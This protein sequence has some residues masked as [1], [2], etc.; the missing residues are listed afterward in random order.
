MNLT[1]N[2]RLDFQPGPVPGQMSVVVSLVT[3]GGE[4][5]ATVAPAT[6][7]V[8]K[9]LTLGPVQITAGLPTEVTNTPSVMPSQAAAQAAAQAAVRR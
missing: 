3:S 7:A 6:V 9:T 5:I 8:G 4:V 2:L 1:C